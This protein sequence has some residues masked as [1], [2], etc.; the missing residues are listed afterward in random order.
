MY[1][2]KKLNITCGDL[3][4][5]K[6]QSLA[7]CVSRDLKMSAG[8]AVEFR[9]KYGHVNLL[10]EQGPEVGNLVYLEFEFSDADTPIKVD[11]QP[12][13][14]FYLVTKELYF[15]K[16]TMDNF[17]QCMSQLA[18][19]CHELDVKSLAIPKIG[20]GLD[21]LKFLQVVKIIDN[22]FENVNTDI[23]MYLLPGDPD[24]NKI[25]MNN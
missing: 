14:I 6:A 18:T 2:P 24:Y 20:C 12:K 1:Q 8:I 15:H 4:K 19:V 17:T 5:S 7:H 10:R 13:Y 3:F 11:G 23:T 16:P 22:L 21:K 25:K 9:E